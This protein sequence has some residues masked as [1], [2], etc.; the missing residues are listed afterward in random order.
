M[1]HTIPHATELDVST[2]T[3]TK[4]EL[5]NEN[6]SRSNLQPTAKM[7]KQDLLALDLQTLEDARQFIKHLV[8]RVEELENPIGPSG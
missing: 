1:I 8:E 2:D 7:K 4:G 5:K 6:S 3:G